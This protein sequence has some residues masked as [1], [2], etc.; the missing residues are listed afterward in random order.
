MH[1]RSFQFI[2]KDYLLE[3]TSKGK[4]WFSIRCGVGRSYSVLLQPY[5]CYQVL[6]EGWRDLVL[7]ERI[8]QGDIGYFKR[9]AARELDLIVHDSQGVEKRY[10]A[11]S[12]HPSLAKPGEENIFVH[13][14]GFAFVH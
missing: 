5:W 2:P 1:I 11:Q 6:M 3:D 4:V 7:G 13:Y 8:Q 9:I 14:Y 12:E 10:D